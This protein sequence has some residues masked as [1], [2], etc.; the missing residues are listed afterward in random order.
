MKNEEGNISEEGTEEENIRRVG[1]EL[2]LEIKNGLCV[3]DRDKKKNK[4]VEVKE[5]E[6]K[7]RLVRKIR[8]KRQMN[9][10]K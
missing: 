7:G 2:E 3:S 10:V 5:E 6:K 9:G 8:Y 4:K 1:M